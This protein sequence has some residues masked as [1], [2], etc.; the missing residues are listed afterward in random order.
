MQCI[1]IQINKYIVFAQ[2]SFIEGITQKAK[3]INYL[4]TQCLW[5]L[6][7][8]SEIREQWNST[9]NAAYMRKGDRR[10]KIVHFLGISSYPFVLYKEILV[11]CIMA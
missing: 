10:E 4:R 5:S 1:Y 11:V 8:I 6:K 9:N 3:D 2:A 7:G